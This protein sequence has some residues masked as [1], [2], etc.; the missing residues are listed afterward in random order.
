MIRPTMPIGTP[1]GINGET[2]E[3]KST[4]LRTFAYLKAISTGCP[5]YNY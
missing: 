3:V 4:V 2:A 1:K 5:S